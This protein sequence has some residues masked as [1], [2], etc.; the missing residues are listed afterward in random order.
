MKKN[1][2]LILLGV[3]V[4]GGLAFTKMSPKGEMM[5]YAAKKS[6]IN[7]SGAPAGKTGAPDESG[8]SCTECHS[9]TLQDGTGFNSI[10]LVDA[11]TLETVTEYTPGSTYNVLV[12]MN[13]TANRKGFETTARVLSNNTTAGTMTAVSGSTQIKTGSS[14]RKYATHI[15][16]ST[17]SQTGWAFT[18]VAPATD[19]GDVIFYMASNVT[20]DN[21]NSSGDVIRTS[22]HTFAAVDNVSVKE[23]V[24][25][26]FSVVYNSKQQ[27]ID[28]DIDAKQEAVYSLNLVDMSG[29]SVL[30]KRLGKFSGES[31]EQ[32]YLPE[33]MQAGVYIVHFFEDNH[34][35]SQKIYIS[36]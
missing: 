7:R 34:S 1:D 32:I 33:N 8:A 28:L 22:Q 12:T 21:S 13:S 10:A 9:G 26:P 27:T 36:K 6:H 15:T 30:F 25:A 16:S 4:I 18:W 17:T 11:A 29:K 35:F 5:R 24:K 23:A 20:N 3:A 31:K 2:V 14:S 19:V